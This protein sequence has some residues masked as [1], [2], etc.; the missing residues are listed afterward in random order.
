MRIKFWGVRGST[1]T[2][3]R[4][5][6]RYGG[7][8]ACIEVRL[9]N[10][11]LIILDCGTGL[12]A[13]GK[14][15]LREYGDRPVHGYIFL[16]HFHWDHIQGIPFFLPLY[17]K[18]N[19]F[20]FHSVCR[21]G[22]ELKGAVEGQMVSPYFPVDMNA[23]GAVRRF[24]DLDE[25]PINLN[26]A[27]I[28][29]AGVLVY[30]AQYTPEVLEGEKMGWG[31]SSW[32]EGTRIAR[33]SGV[34]KLLLFHHDPDND[35]TYIDGLVEKARREFPDV[36]GATEGLEIELPA[37]SM[38][39]ASVT[40]ASNRR[41]ERRY[42]LMLPLRVGWREPS[43][44]TQEAQGVAQDLSRSGIYFVVPDEVRADQP[45][46]LEII[47]PDDIT[48]RGEMALRFV[49]QPLRT[50]RLTEVH[51]VPKPTLGVAARL[52]PQEGSTSHEGNLQP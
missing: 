49:A 52:I 44:Q 48:H 22:A 3:E 39:G 25:R 28:R 33:E 43:G 40:E 2:P 47:I 4:R 38:T 32:L 21:K 17:K 1:P 23:M 12:R 35:D 20:L 15:L 5:N 50:A 37:G 42:Q 16:T 18:G 36:Q 10:G 19:I 34:K 11:T 8:T 45:L 46:E 14:S 30:D 26:G 9:A 31:H 41:R 6:S 27:V 51:G 7:N 13:L 24:Y 29:D